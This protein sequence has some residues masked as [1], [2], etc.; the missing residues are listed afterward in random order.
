MSKIS[1]KE[2]RHLANLARID[3]S[4]DEVQRMQ[5]DLETILS[6]VEDL[7]AVDTENL[8]EI[9]QVTGL[10]NVTRADADGPSCTEEERKAIIDAFIDKEGTFAKV[11]AV[12]K[13][14]ED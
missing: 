5:K 12:F 11:K 9:S 7:Q 1:E 10:T 6:Y 8:P 3:I 2:V 4:D 13:K 14:K